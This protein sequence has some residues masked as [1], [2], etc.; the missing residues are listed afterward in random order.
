M[1]DAPT[2]AN[3]ERHSPFSQRHGI[4]VAPRCSN[5]RRLSSNHQGLSSK[6]QPPSPNSP[7][8]EVFSSSTGMF[9]RLFSDS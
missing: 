6:S 3:V 9:A 5:A 2:D 8:T 7:S 1:L 4:S